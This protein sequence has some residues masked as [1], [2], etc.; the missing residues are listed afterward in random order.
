MSA[1]GDLVHHTV[2]VVPLT[3]SSCLDKL[4]VASFIEKAHQRPGAMTVFPSSSKTSL[5]SSLQ[6]GNG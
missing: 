2:A 1:A 5:Y 4:E 6:P 3:L